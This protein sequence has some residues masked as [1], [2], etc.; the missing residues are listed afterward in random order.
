MKQIRD[1]CKLRCYGGKEASGVEERENAN[2]AK[3]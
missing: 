2:N 3:E 1:M